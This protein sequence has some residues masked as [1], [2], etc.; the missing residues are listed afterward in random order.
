MRYESYLCDIVPPMVLQ[1]GLLLGRN[2]FLTFQNHRYVTLPKEAGRPVEGVL[3]LSQNT[4]KYVAL[5]QPTNTE[6]DY[7]LRY[8]GKDTVSLTFYPRMLMVM[9]VGAANTSAMTGSYFVQILESW[10]LD[11]DAMVVRVGNQSSLLSSHE[12][13][14]IPSGALLG[15]SNGP[16]LPT[17]LENTGLP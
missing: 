11:E 6:N 4:E 5:T 14:E 15:T 10:N 16:M 13:A 1:H 2:S 8:V 9:L 7:H 3:T 12:Y 17:T